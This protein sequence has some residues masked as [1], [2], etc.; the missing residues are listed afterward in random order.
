M[1]SLH[2]RGWVYPIAAAGQSDNVRIIIAYDSA[3]NGGAPTVAALLQDSNVGAA[4][5]IY[6]EINL[7]NR[8]RFK[9]LR[10]IQLFLPSTAG[11]GQMTQVMPDRVNS[12]M[13]NEFIKLR[14]LET[15]YNGTNGGTIADITSGAIIMCCI[16]SVYDNKWAFDFG[17]RL[18]YYD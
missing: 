16:T 9:I 1:K 13:I 18:R 8:E 6:S 14:G 11:A 4:T 5:S 2:V 17:S 10:D 15:I 12:L 7:T 3:P